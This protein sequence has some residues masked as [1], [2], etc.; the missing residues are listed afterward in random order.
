[1]SGRLSFGSLL[2]KQLCILV[3]RHL[4]IWLSVLRRPAHQFGG[5]KALQSSG[6]VSASLLLGALPKALNL[7][8]QAF[9]QGGSACK[10]SQ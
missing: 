2:T 5:L 10:V 7:E 9:N 3:V 6:I 4:P 1:V 8:A